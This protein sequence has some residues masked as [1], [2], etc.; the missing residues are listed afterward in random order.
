MPHVHSVP[1]GLGRLYEKPAP[2]VRRLARPFLERW[3]PATLLFF[4]AMFARVFPA[5]RMA[6]DRCT[7]GYHLSYS[8]RPD[9][10]F[11]HI[12][13]ELDSSSRR[14]RPGDVDRAE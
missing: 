9:G 5:I 12:V 14:S 8:S 11:S 13:V 2:C 4:R 7:S 10:A 3:N 1:G 6:L